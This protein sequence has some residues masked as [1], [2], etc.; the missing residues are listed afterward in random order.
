MGN[1]GSAGPSSGDVTKLYTVDSTPF[2]MGE[3]YGGFSLLRGTRK[4]DKAPVLVFR[5][6][7]AK[8][9]SAGL[10]S[11]ALRQAKK[12]RHPQILNLLDGVET[13]S[14]VFMVTEDATPL[15]TCLGE[16]DLP[17]QSAWGIRCVA[18]VL[19]FLN[20]KCRLV[21]GNVTPWTIFVTPSGDWKLFGL[22][23]VDMDCAAPE[24]TRHQVIPP[25]L[26]HAQWIPAAQYKSP[27]RRSNN[28]RSVE[29]SPFWSLDAWALGC[30]ILDV[31]EQRAR[32][33]QARPNILQDIDRYVPSSCQAQVRQL[34]NEDPR[35]RLAPS[36]F[37]K[38]ELFND[39]FVRSMVF[40]EEL[41]LKNSE[42]KE[43]FFTSLVSSAPNFPI[44]ALERKVIPQAA[45]A[46]SWEVKAVNQANVAVANGQIPT[47][48]A[49]VNVLLCVLDALLKAYGTVKEKTKSEKPSIELDQAVIDLFT[50]N[51]RVVRVNVLQRM[52]RIGG[53]ISLECTNKTFDQICTGFADATP[54]VR[55]LTIKAMVHIIKQLNDQNKNDKLVRFLA[56]LQNDNEPAIRTNCVVCLGLIAPQLSED[57]RRKTLTASF[58]RALKDNFV[59]ARMAGL[60]GLNTC[61]SLMNLDK[62][63]LATKI[64]PMVC[65][66]LVDPVKEV[67]ASAVET[68]NTLMSTLQTL[69]RD[70]ETGQTENAGDGKGPVQSDSLLGKTWNYAASLTGSRSTPAP[71]SQA[72]SKPPPV[73][74]SVPKPQPSKQSTMVDWT[75]DD[76]DV[77]TMIQDEEDPDDFFMAKKKPASKPVAKPAAKPPPSEPPVDIFANDTKAMSF[78]GKSNVQ[79]KRNAPQADLIS[80]DE[81]VLQDPPPVEVFPKG[82]SK[83]TLDA[84]LDLFLSATSTSS[85]NA[86]PIKKAGPN[87]KPAGVKKVAGPPPTNDDF[88]DSLMSN[89]LPKRKT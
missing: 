16:L 14:D 71:S 45:Q 82:G 21:H 70:F 29:D 13:E 86:A 34:L 2:E 5:C 1:Q 37:L 56:Q 62:E 40:L 88:F 87:R 18:T 67:R 72:T 51:D 74:A 58:S 89:P 76:D 50:C 17:S 10:C 6:E 23:I 63:T 80:G 77:E 9:T 19:N 26:K 55:E 57:A 84:D 4:R 32:G 31:Y 15:A 44:G 7:K 12:L 65:P 49:N 33:N 11:N 27:E 22:E 66:L 69:I 83:S 20:E 78:G 53:A 30:V 38:T 54:L 46:I 60:R 3:E 59:H 36:A 39:V 42:K 61:H 64:L 41:Q 43:A 47:S 75:A 8:T 79:K 28:W 73:S 48:P 24:G 85:T 25:L 68:M 81:D 35:T 52:D